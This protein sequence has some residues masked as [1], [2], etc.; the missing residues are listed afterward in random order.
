MTK[1]GGAAPRAAGNNCA[2]FTADH[3]NVVK[4]A[5]AEL[6]VTATVSNPRTAQ[7]CQPR[8]TMTPCGVLSLDA[9]GVIV[10]Q[11][12][13]AFDARSWRGGRHTFLHR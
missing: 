10:A 9:H 8:W 12:L 13:A 7:V 11:S 2:S 3:E 4:P 6:R 5:Q 1:A